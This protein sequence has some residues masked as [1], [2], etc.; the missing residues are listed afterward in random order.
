MVYV[1][2]PPDVSEEGWGRRCKA[3]IDPSLS[4]AR[5]VHGTPQDPPYWPSYSDLTPEQRAFYLDWLTAGRRDGAV[6]VGYA[7][8]YFY[9]LERRYFVDEP[10]WSERYAIRKEVRRLRKL[11]GDNRSVQGYLGTFLDVAGIGMDAVPEIPPPIDR[12]RWEIPLPLTLGLGDRIGR[13]EPLSADWLLAWFLAHPENSLR[14]PATR[15]PVEF[16]ATFR[17]LFADRFTDGLKVT[18]PRRKLSIIYEAASREFTR[19]VTPKVD[20]APVLDVSALRKP[21]EIA[22]E[23]AD[24]AME[25]LGGY[26]RLVGRDATAGNSLRGH[27][28]LP[29]EVRAAFPCEARADL[30]E[31]ARERI[32]A[33]GL[34]PVRDAV[35]RVRGERPEK[36]TKRDLT[37]TADLL[38]RLKIGMAPDPRFALRCP[39]PEEPVVLFDLGREVENLEDV[40]EAYAEALLT[41]TLGAFVAHADGVIAEAEREALMHGVHEANLPSEDER[42][43]LMAN[44]WWFL[45]VP[46]DMSLLRKRLKSAPA[47]QAGALRAALVAA[48]HADGEVVADEVSSLENAYKALGLDPGLVYSDLHAGGAN[49]APVAVRAARAGAAGEVI[50]PEREDTSAGLD[51]ARIAAIRSDTARA[52]SV[53]GSI[54]TD[55]DDEPE[56]EADSAAS[57]ARDAPPSHIDGLDAAHGRLVR[58]LIAQDHWTEDAFDVAARAEGLMPA[59]AVET[60]NEWSFAAHDEAL[61]DAYDGYDIEPEIAAT[62]RDQIASEPETV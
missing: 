38:A 58:T 9:G 2:V 54:F 33:G 10:S 48:A 1:G 36:P 15:C 41:I 50:P 35:E 51:F 11:F 29:A 57:G 43:R 42:R 26:S 7:F 16:E 56:D 18:K 37:E 22:Q 23:I 39:K 60:I 40:S 25:A 24:E 49:D 21:I 45:S 19:T 6:G 5:Q 32:A 30:V 47:E 59:G 12:T 61:L 20:G 4:V 27:L 55:A 13:G 52:S 31:W 62:L 28:M 46:P 34:V 53:L 8:L 14:T 17:A 44:L 3:Y